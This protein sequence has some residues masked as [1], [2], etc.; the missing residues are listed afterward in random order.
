MLD[1]DNV[2]TDPLNSSMFIFMVLKKKKQQGSMTWLNLVKLVV[3]T[4]K[5]DSRC[6]GEFSYWLSDICN[7]GTIFTIYRCT[8][9]FLNDLI[10]STVRKLGYG[11]V[12][13]KRHGNM[14]GD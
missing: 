6:P 13:G 10:A 7:C 5:A 2:R 4:V 8:V 3:L 12:F 11:N 9:E 14:N 1:C